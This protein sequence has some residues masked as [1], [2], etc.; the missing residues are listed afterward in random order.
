MPQTL[1]TEFNPEYSCN[2]IKKDQRRDVDIRFLYRIYKTSLISNEI[3]ALIFCR[4]R[5]CIKIKI[6]KY[7]TETSFKRFT[8]LQ[9]E[10][11]GK[12]RRG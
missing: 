12:G 11:R 4:E 7:L 8:F 9:N 2:L 6:R 10:K 3:N 5:I 1:L